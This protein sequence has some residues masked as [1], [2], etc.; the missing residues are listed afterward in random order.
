M[1]NLNLSFGFSFEDLYA[2]DGLLR[3]DAAF[4][5]QAPEELRTRLLAAREN[6]ASLTGKPASELI[7]A[8]APYVDDF[9][10][11]LFG[12][13]AELRALQERHHELAPLYSVKRRF[14]QR[15]ALTGQT[16]E[17]ALAIDGEKIAAELEAFVLEPLT[18]RS[19]ASHVAKWLDAEA[20]HAQALALATQYTIWA[21][22]TPQ[23][24]AKHKHGI[25][26]RTPHKLDPYHLVPAETASNGL[27]QLQF[28]PDH[29]RSRE[30]FQ[31]T[32]PGTDMVGALDQ[33]HYCIKCHNQG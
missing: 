14:V 31:L 12:I 30:G 16:P 4:L 10:G 26:F 13:S 29:W 22:L 8:L 28:G 9:I 23:G 21:V 25:L 27:V 5:Q 17:K 2:R 3:V 33:T 19:F 7:V 32:D 6:P 18:E 15:K 11:E 1:T 24:K 20:D